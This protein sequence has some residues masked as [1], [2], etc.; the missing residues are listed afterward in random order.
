MMHRQEA[1]EFTAA[2]TRVQRLCAV[3]AMEH[4]RRRQRPVARLDTRLYAQQLELARRGSVKLLIHSYARQ[5]SPAALHIYSTRLPVDHLAQ[6]GPAHRPR[7]TLSATSFSS[8]RQISSPCWT[9][10]ANNRQQHARH[11]PDA[12]RY[13]QPLPPC[14]VINR[15][16]DTIRSS[17]SR[18]SSSAASSSNSSSSSR[19]TAIHPP[20]P[21]PPP[22]APLSPTS[23]PRQSASAGY[24]ARTSS[25]TLIH[26][27][28]SPPD[29]CRRPAALTSCCASSPRDYL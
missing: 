21:P 11:P 17:S 22:S 3:S 24:V 23:P 18:R 7:S 6:P 14:L 20:P 29:D 2:S 10:D 15:S 5:R 19:A 26:A 8:Y 4:Q 13:R 28:S 1:G 16:R 12:H 27:H 25:L 9:S